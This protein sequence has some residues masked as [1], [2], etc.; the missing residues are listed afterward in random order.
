MSVSSSNHPEQASRVYRM[1]SDVPPEVFEHAPSSTGLFEQEEIVR[2][3]G[4]LADC[5]DQTESELV[6]LGCATAF[7]EMSALR[8]SKKLT[9]V[10]VEL[11]N[12]VA[13]DMAPQLLSVAKRRLQ[14]LQDFG[15]AR[16]TDAVCGSISEMDVGPFN[17]LGVAILGVYN[18]DCL[19]RDEA[20]HNGE[21][22]GLDE[23]GGGMRAILGTHTRIFPLVAQDGHLEEQEPIVRYES[24]SNTDFSSIRG[25]LRRHREEHDDIVGMRIHICRQNQEQ[26]TSDALFVSTWFDLDALQRVFRCA[27][28]SCDI[29]PTNA[30]KG[31]VLEVRRMHSSGDERIGVCA[32]AMNNV[33]GNVATGPMMTQVLEKLKALCTGGTR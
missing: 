7:R 24:D 25:S 10:P 32:L 13:I 6:L 4:L 26:S 1:W 21:P 15:V 28:L 29:H 3:G 5:L 11:R 20:E 22:V 12:V 2:V 17:G 16:S 14:K 8:Y 19:L 18:L 9:G 23:Y 31:A 33:F 30:K 27:G